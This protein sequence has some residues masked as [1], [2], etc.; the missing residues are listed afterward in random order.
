MT[1]DEFKSKF[2]VGDKVKLEGWNSEA[3]ISAIGRE[4]FL[5]IRRGIEDRWYMADYWT[6]VEPLKKTK[7]VA[8]GLYRLPGSDWVIPLAPYESFEAMRKD[9]N[10]DHEIFWPFG[11]LIEVPE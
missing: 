4:Y 5:G 7:M 6:L 2:K 8:M 11:P 1:A 3:K 10:S 9:G